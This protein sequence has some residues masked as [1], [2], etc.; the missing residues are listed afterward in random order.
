MSAGIIK[1]KDSI[2]GEFVPVPFVKGEKGD[3]GGNGVSP[4]VEVVRENDSEY[5]LNIVDV[6]G[7]TQTPNL[8]GGG[9][10]NGGVNSINVNQE[11]FRAQNN[12]ITLPDYP[13]KSNEAEVAEGLNNEHFITPYLLDLAL[14]AA[15][16]KK[17]GSGDFQYMNKTMYFENLEKSYLDQEY[18]NY[19]KTYTN[20]LGGF[21][22]L[23][24]T[25]NNDDTSSLI[26]LT[27]DGEPRMKNMP[28]YAAL[29]KRGGLEFYFDHEFEINITA[30]LYPVTLRN[31]TYY[32]NQV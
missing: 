9:S 2:T 29:N 20:E 28:F 16:K 17:G 3:K 22:F 1:I 10:G 7:T 27:I 23:R 12:T 24:A 6:N 4:Y 30:P 25:H 32:I 14:D 5:I 26:N 31:L 15:L 8:K 21:V 13:I 19:S 18:T 11:T